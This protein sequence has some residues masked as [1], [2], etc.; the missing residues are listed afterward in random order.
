MQELIIRQYPCS[1]DLHNRTFETVCDMFDAPTDV[2]L[3]EKEIYSL[4]LKMSNDADWNN[5]LN[6]CVNFYEIQDYIFVHGWIP[7]WNLTSTHIVPDNWWC[8]NWKEARWYNGFDCWKNNVRIPNKTI[9][10]GHWHTSYANSKFHNDGPEF[11]NENEKANFGIFRD[12]GII[13][14]DACTAYSG[15]VNCLVLDF[16]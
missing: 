10:C 2:V 11:D 4:L 13:G 1:H 15:K 14:L 16:N 5:Y 12:D 6:D 3:S 9:V 8:G 7:Y